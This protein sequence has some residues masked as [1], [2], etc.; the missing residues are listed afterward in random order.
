[1][2]TLIF[3]FLFISVLVFILLAIN[4]LI[5]VNRPD[6]EKVSPYECGF[7]PLGDSR[8]QF[9]VQFYL[10]AILFLVFDIE[11]IFLFPFGVT[12][13]Q[14]SVYGFWF[15]LM[16]LIVLTLGLVFELSRGIYPLNLKFKY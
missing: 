16:F 10:V 8:P 1:M 5:S 14:N 9:S 6:T 15:V 12:L 2:N 11:V 13:Y 7:A 3:F 4:Q